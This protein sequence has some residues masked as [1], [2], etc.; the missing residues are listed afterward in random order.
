M[1]V[2]TNTWK[3]KRT[4]EQTNKQKNEWTNEQMNEWM[5]KQTNEEWTNKWTNKK[6]MIEWMNVQGTNEGEADG[7][8]RLSGER[9]F[10]PYRLIKSSLR[11][12]EDG[13]DSPS[14]A[15]RQSRPRNHGNHGYL[16]NQVQLQSHPGQGARGP[17]ERLVNDTRLSD[18]RV[19]TLIN[20]Q[21]RAN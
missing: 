11:P 20:L 8:N 3:N 14:S 16:G 5:N 4:N 6:Q 19:T 9:R 10:V 1:N 15:H 17:S 18:N 12:V 7:K 2:Q 13:W 21:I